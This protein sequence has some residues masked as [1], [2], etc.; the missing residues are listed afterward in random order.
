MSR[1]PRNTN[2]LPVPAS[3]AP[4]GYLGSTPRVSA[5]GG[6]TPRPR[7]RVL[8]NLRSF[9]EQAL[10]EAI[11]PGAFVTYISGR[12]AMQAGAYQQIEN[13]NQMQRQLA[14]TGL[15]AEVQEMGR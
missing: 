15:S 14:R 8:V 12:P 13:A 2:L 9:R 1:P 5:T 7:Y 11:A 6:G 10:V 4:L 3:S